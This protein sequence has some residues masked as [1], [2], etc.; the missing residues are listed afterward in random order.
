MRQTPRQVVKPIRQKT[1]RAAASVLG[2]RK[3]PE[4]T[5]ATKLRSDPELFSE[6]LAT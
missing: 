5:L 4:A 2:V 3:S 1:M 6:R